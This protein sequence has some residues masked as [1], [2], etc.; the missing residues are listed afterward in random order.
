M[1]IHDKEFVKYIDYSAIIKRIEEIADQINKDYKDRNPLFIAI[2][3]GSFMVAGDLMKKINLSCEISFVKVS[4]YND[5]ESTGDVKKLIGLN[6]NIFNRDV[7]LIEDIV[8]SG[9]TINKMLEE[10]RDL[11]AKSVEIA[12]LLHKPESA[13]VDVSVKY[14]GFE[15]PGLFV[16]GY[17]LDYNGIGRNLEDIYQVKPE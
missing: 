10:F 3:N 14:C 1:K 17:G 12:A 15:I 13:K 7:I 4:S 16:V 6:E 2:L 11:G 9:R 5:M 8:D